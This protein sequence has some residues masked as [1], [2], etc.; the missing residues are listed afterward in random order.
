M[1]DAIKL[2]T[3]RIALTSPERRG[4]KGS[5]SCQWSDTHL[6]HQAVIAEAASPWS[7]QPCCSQARRVHRRS[8]GRTLAAHRRRIGELCRCNCSS[9]SRPPSLNASLCCTGAAPAR[10]RRSCEAGGRRRRRW[11]RCRGGRRLRGR[12]R[13]GGATRPA[14]CARSARCWRRR[15]AT[16]GWM[17]SARCF[18]PPDTAR[19]KRPIPSAGVFVESRLSPQNAAPRHAQLFLA[20]MTDFLCS[21]C[22]DEHHVYQP[23]QRAASIILLP[24]QGRPLSL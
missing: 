14:A 17:Q 15:C 10:R 11:R 13:R 1:I 6:P 4:W 19:R 3:R 5:D 8:Q 7:H 18:A 20:G 12:R 21:F 24:F 22:G 23:A 16:S 2:R 9:S